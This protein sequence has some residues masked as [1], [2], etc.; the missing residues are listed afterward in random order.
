MTVQKQEVDETSQNNWLFLSPSGCLVDDVVT[1]H[2]T[3]LM[4][5]L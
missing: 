1:S 5:M 3:R 4:Q 2:A